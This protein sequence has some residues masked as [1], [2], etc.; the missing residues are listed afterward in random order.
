MSQTKNNGRV[1][2]KVE[3]KS[4]ER[5]L[6]QYDIVYCDLGMGVACEKRG[7]RPCVV[8][9]NNIINRTSTNIIIAPLTKLANKRD[10]SGNVK[11]LATHVVLSNKFYKQL[12]F[13]SIIQLEDVRS[14]SKERIAEYVGDLS[15]RDKEL[16]KEAQRF[17][18]DI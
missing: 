6:K 11:L 5:F 12:P 13:T 14:V 15:D 18:F 3:G 8:L 9:G 10:L 17:V 7:M 2:I 16:V 1:Q 4:K